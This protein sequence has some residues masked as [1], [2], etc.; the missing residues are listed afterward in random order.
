MSLR[1]IA[2]ALDVHGLKCDAEGCGYADMSVPFEDYLKHLEAP[3][4]KCGAPL[5]TVEDM[6]ATLHV[7]KALRDVPRGAKPDI[8]LAVKL[9][10]TGLENMTVELGPS[11]ADPIEE[12]MQRSSDNRR[13]FMDEGYEE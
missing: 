13:R 7:I 4:P 2:P 11:K 6:I 12:S 5:L 3:C 9:D 8:G 1:G 10:G